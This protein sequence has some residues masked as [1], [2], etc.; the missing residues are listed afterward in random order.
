MLAVGAFLRRSSSAWVKESLEFGPSFISLGLAPPLHAG[1]FEEACFLDDVIASADK[2]CVVD[3]FVAARSKP[4]PFHELFVESF[5]GGGRVPVGVHAAVIG[6]EISLCDQ[7]VVV[8]A[9][10]IQL[11]YM[12]LL[13]AL[14]SASVINLLLLMRLKSGWGRTNPRG[15]EA[16][17]GRGPGPGVAALGLL[18][19]RIP[20]VA[21]LG[22]WQLWG[23]WWYV[24]LGWHWGADPGGALGC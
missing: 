14:R 12:R 6:T 19:V 3:D 18:V 7:L 24:D 23:C 5:N 17:L 8:D 4:F 21:A 16:A 13:L 11:A 1:I 22:L 15:P 9:A 10:E 2:L 20:G